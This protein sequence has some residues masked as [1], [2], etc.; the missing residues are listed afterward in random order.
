MSPIV[1]EDHPCWVPSCD[2]CGEGDNSE[3]G[4]SFHYASAA[5]AARTLRDMD[6]EQAQD[7]SWLC[8]ECY[9]EAR[10]E[11]HACPHGARCNGTCGDC[12]APLTATVAKRA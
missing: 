4:G 12:P 1:R 6:W 9:G 5:E 7:G 10:A 3:Y 8:F 11:Q 2:R